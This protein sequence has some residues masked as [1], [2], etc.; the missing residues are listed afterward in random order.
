MTRKPIELTDEDV[1][2]VLNYKKGDG[3]P[4]KFYPT[5]MYHSTPCYGWDRWENDK[6]EEQWDEGAKYWNSL[7]G[8]VFRQQK[9]NK[10]RDKNPHYLKKSK[11][12]YINGYHPNPKFIY[13]GELLK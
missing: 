4:V 10:I 2:L 11:A 1:L 6:F 7:C 9:L 8:F 13:Y 3:I 12:N 5:V